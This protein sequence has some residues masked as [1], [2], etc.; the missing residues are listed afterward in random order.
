MLISRISHHALAFEFVAGYFFK[1]A[2]SNQ[3]L[4]EVWQGLLLAVIGFRAF[5]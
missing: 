5:V 2:S 3:G 1:L 4:A